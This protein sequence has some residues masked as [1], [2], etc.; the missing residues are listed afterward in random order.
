MTNAETDGQIRPFISREEDYQMKATVAGA[1]MALSVTAAGAQ[2]DIASASAVLPGCKYH[3]A[4]ADGQDPELTVPIALAAGYCAAVFDVLV[5][6][7]A[8]DP[9]MCLDSDTDKTT[10]MLAFI[11]YIEARPQRMRER[12]LVLAREA[13]RQTWPCAQG[14]GR[15]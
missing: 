6:S 11:H 5:S 13:L 10:A 15:Q 7:S 3:V 12:F 1:F 2:Q 9:V 8:L 4:L 14:F